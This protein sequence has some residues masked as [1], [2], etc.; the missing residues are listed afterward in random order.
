[1]F[2]YKRM[3]RMRGVTS[4]GHGRHRPTKLVCRGGCHEVCE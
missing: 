3:T 4:Q 2:S 1:M